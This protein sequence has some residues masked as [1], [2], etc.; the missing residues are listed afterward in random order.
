MQSDTMLE[1]ADMEHEALL[2]GKLNLDEKFSM[3]IRWP[4]SPL[5]GFAICMSAFDPKLATE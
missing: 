5:Q 1:E 4:L 2:F 3:D